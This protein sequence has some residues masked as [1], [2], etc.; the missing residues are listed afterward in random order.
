MGGSAISEGRTGVEVFSCTQRQ[1]W[2]TPSPF[3]VPVFVDY[4][5]PPLYTLAL[6]I[7]L[8]SWT[9]REDPSLER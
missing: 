2:N 9:E 1:T 7:M 4:L 5:L 8:L 6:Q 3:P